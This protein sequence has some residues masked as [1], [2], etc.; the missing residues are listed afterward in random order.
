MSENEILAEIRHIRDEHARECGYDVH[1]L[2]ERMRA[3]TAQLEAE[4]WQ[5]VSP[6]LGEITAVVR[7]DPPD[8]H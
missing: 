5:V 4:G 8:S 2:F 6:A 7:E 1:I 3:E